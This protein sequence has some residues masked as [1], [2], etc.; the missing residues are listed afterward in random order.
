MVSVQ[1]NHSWF[2][3][4]HC[5]ICNAHNR[6]VW[7]QYQ[8]DLPSLEPVEPVD[9]DINSI[10][11]ITFITVQDCIAELYPILEVILLQL[12]SNKNSHDTF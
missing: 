5:T 7:N 8:D 4:R 6:P 11:K 2:N 1:C 3:I 10:L 12:A 9:S